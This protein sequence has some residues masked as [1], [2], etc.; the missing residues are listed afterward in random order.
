[1]R[2]FSIAL[3]VAASV[4]N[5]FGQVAPLNDAGV[6]FGH[7]HFR[8]SDPEATK[9]AWIDVFGATPGKTGTAE[10]LKIPGVLIFVSKAEMPPSGGTQGSS[11][12]HIGIAVKS[13]AETKAKA[14][15][16]GIAWRELTK[17]VQAFASFPEGVTVEVMEVKDQA[18]PVALHHVHEQV[19]DPAAA[20]A[21]YVKEFGAGEGTRRNLPAA[22]FPGATEVDFLKANMPQAPTKGRALDHIGFEVKDLEATLKRLQA[23]GVQIDVPLRDATKTIGLKIAFVT[24]PNGTYI[25]LTEGLAGK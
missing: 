12:H 13:Y 24:D 18:T 23:D 8:V 25:E 16:A 6:A 4:A 1:M 5:V 21:W 15:A 10:F 11:V 22:M 9:K 2:T 19:P 14:D 17:D 3:F 20:R 7:L